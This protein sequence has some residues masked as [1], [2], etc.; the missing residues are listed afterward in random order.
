MVANLLPEAYTL[1]MDHGNTSISDYR[2]ILLFKFGHQFHIA[3]N[4][5][6]KFQ[7]LKQTEK[8][9]LENPRKI[10]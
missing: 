1:G 2:G 6:R 7:V 10:E 9:Y 8:H 3:T 4:K 5:I